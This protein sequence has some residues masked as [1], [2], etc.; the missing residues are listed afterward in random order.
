MNAERFKTKAEAL[1]DKLQSLIEVLP[2]K[3]LKCSVSQKVC[4]LNSLGSFESA[5]N[6]VEDEDFKEEDDEN[7]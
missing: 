7:S 4:L 6:G 5:V 1:I 2:D 3:G